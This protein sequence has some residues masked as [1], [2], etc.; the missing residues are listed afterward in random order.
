MSN[1]AHIVIVDDEK[2]IQRSVKRLLAFESYDIICCNNAEEAM[3][4]VEQYLPAVIVS[5][6]HMPGM[7]GVDLLRK[8]REISPNTSRILFSGHIDVEL[9]RQAVNG[10]EVYRFITKPWND[11]ELVMAVR[12]GVERSQLL[13]ENERL[14]Q[15]SIQQ[16]QQLQKFNANLEAMVEQRSNALELR[17]S[18]LQLN[19]DVLDHL[20]V[21]VVGIDPSGQIVLA[22]ALAR[23]IFNDIILGD[24]ANACLPEDLCQWAL[25]STELGQQFNFNTKTSPITFELVALDQRGLVIVGHLLGAAHETYE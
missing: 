11:E 17:N 8:V 5:D 10:G 24:P 25:G 23:E 2:P 21:I 1:N 4:A 14:H 16:N 6:Q 20:P 22:N 13:A 19:Q 12:L 18:A 9:L 15:K 7:Q 3:S